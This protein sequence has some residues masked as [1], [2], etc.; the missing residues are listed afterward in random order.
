MG[1]AEAALGR[2]RTSHRSTHVDAPVA[3]P[4]AAVPAAAVPAAVVPAAVVLAAAEHA[5]MKQGAGAPR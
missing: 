4:A 5:S 3:V 2:A 1:E